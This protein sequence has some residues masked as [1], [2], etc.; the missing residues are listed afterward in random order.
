MKKSR[1]ARPQERSLRQSSSSNV[2]L[3]SIKST[4][5][6]AI[7]LQARGAHTP[8]PPSLLRP[9]SR[10]AGGRETPRVLSRWFSVV[11]ELAPHPAWHRVASWCSWLS[12]PL[13]MRKVSSSNLDEAIDI[14]FRVF[15]QPGVDNVLICPPTYGMYKGA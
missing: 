14:L 4:N 7:S 3:L 12:R 10:R 9:R 2:W 5:F 13:H 15:C 6:G 11:Y 8:A 1:Y